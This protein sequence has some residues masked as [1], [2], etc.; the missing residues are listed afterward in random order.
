MGWWMVRICLQVVWPVLVDSSCYWQPHLSGTCWAGTEQQGVS[1]DFFGPL[2]Q[3]R[4][5]IGFAQ[6]H[7]AYQ[8]QIWDAGAGIGMR[9][10]IQPYLAVGLN[11]F[12]D[13]VR[14]PYQINRW[15]VGAGAELFGNFWHSRFNAYFPGTQSQRIRFR[16]QILEFLSGNEIFQ[17]TVVQIG[18]NQAYRGFDTELGVAPIRAKHCEL[19]GYGG[20]FYF[21]SPGASALQGPRARIEY[22][23]EDLWGWCQ[24]RL[25]LG[26]DW[27]YDSVRGH[28]GAFTATLRLPTGY[29]RA[30]CCCP[31]RSICRRMGDAVLRDST[32]T[33]YTRIVGTE[34]L[35]RE[36]LAHLFFVW[37]SLTPGAGTEEDPTN[38]ADA[39]VRSTPGDLF[40]FMQDQG[41][42]QL[43]DFGVNSINLQHFQQMRGYGN[44]GRIVV[45]LPS[46]GSA[47]I[48]PLPGQ[49]SARAQLD[50]V[51]GNPVVQL[52]DFNLV[53]GLQI[54][55]GSH[56]IMGSTLPGAS[57][58]NMIM[59]NAS[60]DSL[61]LSGP[62]TVTLSNS[63]LQGAGGH[64]ISLTG[65]VNATIMN[66]NIGAAMSGISLVANAANP[67]IS[68]ICNNSITGGS[69]PGL[70]LNQ[71]STGRYT[72]NLSG[73]TVTSGTAAGIELNNTTGA[74]DRL[75][76]TNFADNTVL[77]GPGIMGGIVVTQATFAHASGGHT[78]IGTTGNRV[79]QAGLELNGVSGEL[80]FSTLNIANQDG[81]GLFAQS[82][83]G[84]TFSLSTLEGTID[85]ANGPALELSEVTLHSSF[86]S[87]L[88]TASPT[89]GV[90]L[91]NIHG[92]LNMK[93]GS[94][95][96][97]TG[98]AF[99]ITGLTAP[100]VTYSG[101]IT[102]THD[103]MIS[104][105]DLTGGSVIF[106]GPSLTDT[107]AKGITVLNTDCKVAI[108][109]ANLINSANDAIVLQNNTGSFSFSN[110]HLQGLSHRGL[111]ATSIDN[112]SLT[113][114][115]FTTCNPGPDPLIEL[116][117][118]GEILTVTNNVLT[119]ITS[120]GDVIRAITTD[121]LNH[122]VTIS[123]NI[124]SNP[125]AVANGGI[126]LSITSPQVS[127]A[128]SFNRVNGNFLNTMI[129][130]S[131]GGIGSTGNFSMNSN[132]IDVVG[133]LGNPL[134]KFATLSSSDGLSLTGQMNQNSLVSANGDG[135]SCC[136]LS[137]SG[138]GQAVIADVTV[139]TNTI[140][141]IGNGVLINLQNS[142]NV[143]DTLSVLVSDNHFI[144]CADSAV[145]N[146]LGS[147]NPDRGF[148]HATLQDNT[149]TGG[150]LAVP[151]YW[152]G[153][154]GVANSSKVCATL[155]GNDSTRAGNGIRIEQSGTEVVS[156]TNLATLS[157]L[158]H[159]LNVTV[160]G[161][162]S[163]LGTVAC[164]L[165]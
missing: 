42:I 71:S 45:A 32:A 29:R 72:L 37:E 108:E 130:G 152:I 99:V 128:M 115:T 13:W 123:N 18:L 69:G 102:N 127:A 21:T 136:D 164:P 59:Q 161:S 129:S 135:L 117:T 131:L 39:L 97:A 16:P 14:S 27:R 73:N 141:T 88:S 120:S 60:S 153:K 89:H 105:T 163:D 132:Q 52:A 11:G 119:D 48:T 10:L 6:L 53:D 81:V 38:L 19:W 125:L 56:Q 121:S 64:G 134:I 84:S 95:T 63:T 8:K 148:V 62:S 43:S 44:T 87:I 98:G 26:G 91:Q 112:L 22:R 154:T 140:T 68:V 20:Y 80:S 35:K 33:I 57:I 28:R 85:T 101:T 83:S 2:F 92:L 110:G 55:G 65:G 155:N 1:G 82:C 133:S 146:V 9:H 34:L 147:S 103:F 150:V 90:T 70:S 96:G 79:Q 137:S 50:G 7:G 78:R 104:I 124:L 15:Q 144:N 159:G 116:Q 113:A 67:S 74:C 149:D 41:N 143:S 49:S 142:K 76:I 145:L 47:V 139:S 162:V 66:T 46:G 126:A 54:N 3:N 93:G 86:D 94:V 25:T 107:A 30:T 100:L 23:M 165:P 156:A 31:S 5:S 158:N 58:Y 24:A 106:N 36:V 77:G 17:D 151:V 114:T 51:A 4:Q 61:F 75:Q 111:L 12:A 40:I 109:H 118:F 138:A 160:V 122:A 157:A